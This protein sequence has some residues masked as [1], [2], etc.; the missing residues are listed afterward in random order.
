MSQG[1]QHTATQDIEACGQVI[2]SNMKSISRFGGRLAV[3]YKFTTAVLPQLDPAQRAEVAHRL[4]EG[5]EDAMS[6][7]DDIALPAEY[8]EALL[9]QVNVLLTALERPNAVLR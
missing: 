9:A 5:V 6:L 4:R 3:L 7:T 2:A 8:H 1:Q